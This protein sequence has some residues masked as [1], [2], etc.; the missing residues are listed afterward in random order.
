[1]SHWI[2]ATVTKNRHWN[3][4]LFSLELEAPID[5]FIPGQF[6]KLGMD[7]DGQRVQRAYS[8]V[9]PPSDNKFEIYA[10]SIAD[11]LLSP[12]LFSLQPGDTIEVTPEASGFF[13]LDEVPQGEHLW[14]LATGT[15]LG[16]YLS[17]LRTAEPWSRFRRIVLVHA[18]RCASDLSYQA[19]IEE[20]KKKYPS[21]LVVQPFVSREP[22]PNALSGRITHALNDGM[23]ERIIDLPLSLDKSQIMLCGN[24]Q[25][26]KDTKA[27]LEQKGFIKNLRSK[28]G[29]ITMEHYW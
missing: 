22:G 15:A 26:V 5:P 23:L 14:M 1:M 19:E 18:V 4:T 10:T 12:K 13:T 6:I 11:G 8:L 2:S 25:M 21:Q 24:P 3:N 28:P 9:N 17:I 7:I 29:Q 27:I 16:P 20:L